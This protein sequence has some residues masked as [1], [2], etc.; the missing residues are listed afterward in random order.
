[1]NKETAS[2]YYTKHI[3]CKAFFMDLCD[4]LE[5]NGYQHSIANNRNSFK[6]SAYLFPAGAKDEITYYGKPLNSFRFSNYWNWYAPLSRC[7]NKWVI[8]CF[9]KDMPRT[10]KRESDEKGSKAIIGNAVCVMGGDEEYHV[11]YGEVFD[12]KTKTWKWLE[13]DPADIAEMVGA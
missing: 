7:K 13:T 1:M 2:P 4:I 3:L 12:R 5:K 10:K 11:V 8:Q 9:T 6:F